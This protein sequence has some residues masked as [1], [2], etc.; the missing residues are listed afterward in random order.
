MDFT[1]STIFGPNAINLLHSNLI[2]SQQL[3]H[4]GWFSDHFR[5]EEKIQ[6][7]NNRWTF[8]DKVFSMM[9]ISDDFNDSMNL[10]I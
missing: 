8:C 4:I 10:N 2:R 1:D 7:F 3:T 9:A 6:C 5:W